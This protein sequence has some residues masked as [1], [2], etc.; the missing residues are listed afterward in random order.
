M[1]HTY[2][3]LNAPLVTTS[4]I[5]EALRLTIP[6]QWNIPIYDDFPSVSDVVR[7]GIYVSDVHTVSRSVNQLG[8]T[9]CSNMYNAVDQFGVTYIS[10]QDDPYNIQVNSIIANLATDQINGRPLFDGYFSV[11][12]EQ[13]LVYGPTQAERH[14]WT[15]QMTRLEFNT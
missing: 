1:T 12:F 14:D 9:Y 4:E 2:V 10:F 11:T 6:Q 8:V 13:N 3:P 7:Y 15:F 5:I